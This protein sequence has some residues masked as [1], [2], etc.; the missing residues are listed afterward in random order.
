MRVCTAFAFVE[1]Q[2]AARPGGAQDHVG[3]RMDLLGTR[4]RDAD[5]VIL[6]IH[7]QQR[8]RDIFQARHRGR[9]LVELEDTAVAKENAREAIIELKQR[10]RLTQQLQV[11]AWV[12]LEDFVRVTLCI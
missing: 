5:R 12:S 10:L 4:D 2:V 9:I 3:I 8:H 11:D 1:R 7:T 6:C